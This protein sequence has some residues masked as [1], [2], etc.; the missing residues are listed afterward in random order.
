MSP[1]SSAPIAEAI[2][3]RSPAVHDRVESPSFGLIEAKFLA[4]RVRNGTVRRVRALRRLR[5]ARDRRVVQVLAPPG[6]GKTSLV[7]QWAG[8]DP[9]SVAWLTADDRD[10]DPVAFL[11]YLAAAIDRVAPLDPVVFTEIRSGAVSGR[12]AVGRLLA[13][14]SRRAEPLIIVIDDAQRVTDR[15]CLDALAEFVT[16]LPEA[17]AVVIASRGPV[18]L[19][20]SR[21]RADGSLLEIGPADLA[22]DDSE[23]AML[24]SHLGVSVP[25]V[26]IQRLNRR[27]GGWPALLALAARAAHRSNR[28]DAIAQPS[29]E[30]FI[31]DYLRSELL[32][33]R[34]EAEITFMTRTSILERLAGPVCD[35][36]VDRPGSAEQLERLARSTL[37]VDEYAGSYRYHS[38]LRDFLRGELET[39]EP[40][41]VAELDGRAAAWYEENGDT[42]LAV[43]HAFAA[44]DL[45]LAATTMGRGILRLHWSG[46]GATLRAWLTR[47]SDDALFERPWLAAL[48]AW[49]QFGTADLA[50]VEHFA[51]IV[52]RGTLEERPPDGT[53]SS[54]SSRAMLRAA[55][56]RA[57]AKDMLSNA[58][59]AVG[60]EAPGSPWRDFALWLLAIARMAN[61][62][63][64]GA[65]AALDDA[66][67]TARPARNGLTYCIL[68]HRALV[69]IDRQ[70]WSAAAAFAE[71]A[72]AIG[73]AR[74]VEG[75]VAS[76]PA[77][78]A[79]IRL[80]IHGG[81]V[82]LARQQLA[83]A[84]KVRGL[85]TAEVP[86]LSVVC[87]LG[88]ARAH[89]AV[90]DGDGARA[91]LTQASQVIRLRP[92]LGP[93][94]GE[95]AAMQATLA[96]SPP[97]L[98]GGPSALTV[99]E[100]RVLALLPF[101]LSFKEIA[102]RLG[103]K[104]TT[105]KTHALAI[106][107]KLG[108]STRGEAVEIAVE[109]G[110]L[111]RFLE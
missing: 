91:V 6:Y 2:E 79:D 89:L 26:E 14:I 62:D 64:A 81:D 84:V 29:V 40:D 90:G 36:V 25:A 57:G 56:G 72:R 111:E 77:R 41:R 37:L 53:A 110:L 80:A 109:A 86:A 45:D 82:G 30:L 16:Y 10:N 12:S 102:Q 76:V 94:P 17:S 5:A 54:E 21:W 63:P 18:D 38:L 42:E 83:R 23:A 9:R 71:E 50:R 51:D 68:G 4:P 85:L 47:I 39:R 66:V 96:A 78:I 65:S 13:A 104:A 28:P 24:V 55:M 92:D 3:H 33:G 97:A 34:S 49:E 105:V 43:D 74:Q 8:G 93:L 69:A 70:D 60:L 44:G 35:V 61:G 98:A 75:Y 99:A 19:P 32:E 100:L 59:R 20:F 27:T 108:A 87:L 101:Y 15:T 46:R 58:T 11:A 88:L 103:V 73:V 1:P 95:V 48:A 106:Y 31:A 67:A 22:M 7:A 52:E 107:G